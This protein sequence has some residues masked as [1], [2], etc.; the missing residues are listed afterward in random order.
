MILQVGSSDNWGERTP[1][2]RG[3][4][5]LFSAIYRGYEQ[6]PIYSDSRGLPCG[7]V[8]FL[9]GLSFGDGQMSIG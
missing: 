9:L 1:I 2:S 7:D 8:F 5:T 3:N 4:N 6:H